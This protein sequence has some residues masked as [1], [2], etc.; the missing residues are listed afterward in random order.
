MEEFNVY[1]IDFFGKKSINFI[2]SMLKY[3][4]TIKLHFSKNEI[5][6]NE[7]SILYIKT[8]L[9]YLIITKIFNHVKKNG[10]L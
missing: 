5:K 10:N 1:L 6:V 7:L 3:F 2:F 9:I 4:Y 8:Y